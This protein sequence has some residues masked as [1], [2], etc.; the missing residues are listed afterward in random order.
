MSGYRQ[1]RRQARQARRA[2]MQPMMVI[3]SGDPLPELAIAVI[4]RWAFRHRSAFAPF[5]VALAAFIAAGA[6]HGAPRAMVGARC[7]GNRRDTARRSP[8]RFRSCAGIRPA[9]GSPALVSRL[10]DKCGIGR[11]IER[12]YAATVT[13]TA[14]GWLAAAIAIGPISQAAAGSRAYRDGNSRYPVVV[15]PP[16]PRES[17][18]RAQNI[19]L[20]RYRG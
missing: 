16:A 19:R 7:G 6:A 11:A 8:S 1:M 20:A 17:P 9:A 2:G 15:P 12:A 13:A 10:W 18:R 3:N 4:A 14:G 5:W